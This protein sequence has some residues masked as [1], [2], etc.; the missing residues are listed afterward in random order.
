MDRRDFFKR[1]MGVAVAAVV[2]L[3]AV[4]PVPKKII[5]TDFSEWLALLL[6]TEIDWEVIRD[7]RRIAGMGTPYKPAE[8][9]LREAGYVLSED[10]S[11]PQL[12]HLGPSVSLLSLEQKGALRQ[13]CEKHI[14]PRVLAAAPARMQRINASVLK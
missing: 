5:I 10:I 9:V 13:S 6:Q 1:L 12:K 4:A 8:E 14:S 2:P 3:P 7:I 11:F